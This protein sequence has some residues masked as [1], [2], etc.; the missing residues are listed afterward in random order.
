[1]KAATSFHASYT[2]ALLHSSEASAEFSKMLGMVVALETSQLEMPGWSK[3]VAPANVE[4][5]VVTRLV[6]QVSC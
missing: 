4:V 2:S 1:M 5:I 3:L 6:S